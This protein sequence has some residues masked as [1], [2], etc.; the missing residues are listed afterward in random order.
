MRDEVELRRRVAVRVT[1]AA[2]ARKVIQVHE[3]LVERWIARLE[4]RYLYPPHMSFQPMHSAR[5]LTLLERT[6][7]Y[8]SNTG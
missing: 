5:V 1:A 6:Y 7:K 8:M 3:T 2:A 4:K